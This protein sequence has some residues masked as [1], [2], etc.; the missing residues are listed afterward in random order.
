MTTTTAFPWNHASSSSSSS[1]SKNSNDAFASSTNVDGTTTILAY[2]ALLS[3]ASSR[4]TFPKFQNFRH[5]QVRGGLRRVFAHPHLFLLQSGLIDPTETLAFASL[6][7]EFAVTDI[8]DSSS[9]SSSSTSSSPSFVAAAFDVVMDDEQKLAFMKREESYEFVSVPYYNL[10]NQSR[11]Q[12]PSKPDGHGVICVASTDVRQ[13]ADVVEQL[14]APLPKPLPI[15]SIWHWPRDSGLL[16]A[17]IYLRHCLLAIEKC[18]SVAA[19][20]SFFKDTYLVDRTTTLE[21][22]LCNPIVLEQVMNSRPPPEL[23][24][25]FGG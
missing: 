20:S 18:G 1:S 9:S 17:N 3:E 8:I 11:Q 16:P 23:A 22:Y 19:R 5:V 15:S 14:L 2:G 7:A 21:E 6:S 24:T 25:R 12:K 10:I 13:G 4:L